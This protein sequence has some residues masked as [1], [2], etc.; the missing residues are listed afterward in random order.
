MRGNGGNLIRIIIIHRVNG[1]FVLCVLHGEECVVKGQRTDI[2]AE[3]GIVG[4]IFGYDVHRTE[5]CRL[6]CFNAL[7]RV[8][9]ACRRFLY[10]RLV[11]IAL[12]GYK[13]G[14]RLETALAGNGSARF[15][16]LLEGAVYI[17]YFCE[18]LCCFE[19]FVY[20]GRHLA[21]LG[22]SRANLF[23]ALFQPAQVIKPVIERAELLVVERSRDLLAVSC[24]KR[25]SIPI[26][27]ELYRGF[28]L[29][30]PDIQLG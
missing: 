5:K 27:Y 23:L 7:F 21:L 12:F 16:F 20:L 17:L 8:D 2:L 25:D 28:H 19:R 22:Y 9:I 4:D 1:I 24:D 14:E 30:E 29:R 6:C 10:V 13:L 26:V 11:Y 18:N 3:I 15:L